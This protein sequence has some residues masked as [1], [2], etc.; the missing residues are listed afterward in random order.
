MKKNILILFVAVMG[1]AF[2]FSSCAKYE[3][4]PAFSLL[5]KK[6]RLANTWKVE[7]VT[8]TTPSGTSSDWT[9]AFSSYVLTIE[10]DGK[11]SSTSSLGS[12]AG[13]WELGE[14][15]DDVRFISSQQGSTEES[16]RILKLKSKELWW[17]QTQQN[18]DV[19]EMHFI[20]Q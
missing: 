15:G 13:T 1:V 14:D 10:K 8:S 18:G 16:Y 4:G 9:S 5:S 11:W 6:A 3:D 20:E 2:T 7:H 12:D 19:V 17:K